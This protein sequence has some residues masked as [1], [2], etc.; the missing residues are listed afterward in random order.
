MNYIRHLTGYFD[1]VCK[2]HRLNPTHISIYMAIF[3]F[4]NLNRFKN[5]LSI[6]RSEIMGLSKVSSKNTY[7]KVMKELHQYGYFRYEPSYHPLRGSWVYML[8]F[9]MAAD[10]SQYKNETG[11]GQVL[12]KQEAGPVQPEDQLSS[13]SLAG[14]ES[15][16]FLNISKRIKHTKL[17]SGTKENK[18]KREEDVVR[19]T[20]E[21]ERLP[22]GEK[23]VEDGQIE[24]NDQNLLISAASTVSRVLCERPPERVPENMEVVVRFFVASEYPQ[25]QASKFFHY[26]NANGWKIGG[27]APIE[28]WQS[29][30][31]S[32]MLHD[33]NT[34]VNG[35][36]QKNTRS[37]SGANRL[38]TS[39]NK[40]YSEPL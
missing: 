17:L 21:Q 2:D 39:A 23:N 11:A 40:N 22:P 32:W 29:A 10:T 15:Q 16:S 14:H 36:N 26:Y 9:T 31:H 30:A 3:Q 5:P 38:H 25:T 34:H 1:R 18:V 24:G 35:T 6:S 37:A 7:H 13:E 4:W 12:D 19:A 8:A 20:S 33:Q 28:N 27:K